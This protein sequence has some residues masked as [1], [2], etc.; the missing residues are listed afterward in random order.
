[1]TPRLRGAL[2]E[3]A[4][5]AALLV[6]GIAVAIGAARMPATGGFSGVGPAAM[7]GI[8]ATG[9]IVIG[10]WLLAESLTGGWRQRE[11]A[12]EDRGEHAFFAPGFA[13]VS[14]GLFAQMALIH[15]AGFVIAAT[16]LF[17][18]VARGFGSRKPARDAAI[19]ALLSTAI[20][21]FFVQF[22]NVNLPAGWLR[23]LLGAAGI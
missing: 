20:F 2:V 11:A 14:A 18:G 15:T 1:M 7:P 4:I 6:A 9:L 19:G 21:L 10:L 23:P 17:V 3:L 12:P 16:A 22:L 13:W 5:A 8:V